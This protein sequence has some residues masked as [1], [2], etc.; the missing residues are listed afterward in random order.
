MN[1]KTISRLVFCGEFAFFEKR[2]YWRIC[3][4]LS[5]GVY[6]NTCALRI[7]FLIYITPFRE[8]KIRM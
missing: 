3:N 6:F 7:L 1:Y 8:T 2:I 4:F 5:I